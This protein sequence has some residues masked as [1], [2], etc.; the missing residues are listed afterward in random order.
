MFSKRD[1]SPSSSPSREQSWQETA[2]PEPVA[3][4]RP[5]PPPQPPRPPAPPPT[6]QP[7][8]T[9]IDESV[10]S[11]RLK[12]IGNMETE[13]DIQVH[14]E[15]QGDIRARTLTV[16][17]GAT[18]EGVVTAATVQ[19]TGTIKGQVEADHVRIAATGFMNGDILYT[20]LSMEEG[21]VLDGKV[22]RQVEEPAPAKA[23]PAAS[24]SK[25]A[26]TVPPPKPVS[27]PVTPAAAMAAKELPSAG[28]ALESS[29]KPATGTGTGG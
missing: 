7:A 27:S 28:E 11:R 22:R 21:A 5:A 12:I 10:I 19:I 1:R 14:G 13:D 17:E 3:E 26:A 6:P 9:Q 2:K 24:S 18:V 20:T 25:P 29:D 8:A 4:A 15:V 23:V 16:A